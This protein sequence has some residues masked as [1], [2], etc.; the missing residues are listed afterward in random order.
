MV[1]VGPR[2][3]YVRTCLEYGEAELERVRR[4]VKERGDQVSQIATELRTA[5]RA[6]HAARGRLLAMESA[7]DSQRGQLE[8]DFEELMS[9]P[10]VRAVEAE[11]ACVRILTDTI[12]IEHLG[13]CYR[14]G[15]FALELDLEQGI[16][17][18]NLENANARKGWDHPHIQGGLP[19]LGNL[20]DGFEKLLGECQLVPLV[21]M[22]IEF[23]EGIN[24]DTAYCSI[25]LWERVEP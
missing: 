9:L 15:K 6:L 14:I 1:E 19:C 22:L 2:S 10:H 24:P 18:L 13:R 16:R 5:S 11:G 4:E 7:V 20:R 21:A 25:E 8:S 3:A 17:V 12:Y 23:L